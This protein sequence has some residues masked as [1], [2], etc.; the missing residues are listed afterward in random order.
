LSGPFIP[1][2]HS[3]LTGFCFFLSPF[4]LFILVALLVQVVDG[5]M[6]FMTLCSRRLS[7]LPLSSVALAG[8]IRWV[9]RPTR[10]RKLKPASQDAK[11]WEESKN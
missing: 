10:W 8:K 11:S 3:I 4:S 2:S 9:V 5:N 7:R 6:G 1:L